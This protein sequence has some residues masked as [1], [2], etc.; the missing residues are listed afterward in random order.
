MVNGPETIPVVDAATLAPLVRR[1]LGAHAQL[2]GT[3]RTSP[4]RGGFGGQGLYRF[5]GQAR[6]DEGTVP[7][8]VVLKISPPPRPHD[9]PAAWDAPQ[10]EVSAYRSR[11]LAGLPGPLVAP[12]CL[13]LSEGPDGAAWL[14]LEAITDERPGPWDLDGYALAARHVGHFNGACL[15]AE[16]LPEEPWFSQG[17]LQQYVAA[18][19]TAAARL[20]VPDDA[21]ALL[22]QCFP[23]AV[24]AWV[25]ELWIE[26]EAF[27]TALDRLPQTVCHHDAFRRNLFARRA[28]DGTEQTVA[29]DWAFTGIGAVGADLAPLVIGSLMLFEVVDAAPWDLV[30]TAV[31]G[32]LVGLWEAGWSGDEGVVRLG[33]LATAALLYTVCSA[34]FMVG[35]LGDPSRHPAFERSLGRP[36]GDAVASWVELRPFQVEL[37]EEAR[38]LL[39]IRS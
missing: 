27:L 36:L 4:L 39:R 12:R 2:D 33:F 9:D 21:H 31:A 1:A 35:L 3:W 24:V 18:E 20:A 14:W 16:S 13:G 8:S 32:Y 23:P 38:R 22:R 6:V 28:A 17:W 19:G 7:W 30:E 25:R 34:G 29:V 15:V 37:V 11:F 10:R 26:R 5:D